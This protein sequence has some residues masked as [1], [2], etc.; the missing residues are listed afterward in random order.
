MLN[1]DIPSEADGVRKD[2]P[3]KR[4]NGLYEEIR[5]FSK[6]LIVVQE[7]AWNPNGCSASFRSH[8]S[9]PVAQIDALQIH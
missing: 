7:L 1:W 4:E 8:F 5:S 9:D 2:G 3:D 6:E